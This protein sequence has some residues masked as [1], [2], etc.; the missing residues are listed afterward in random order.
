MGICWNSGC[1][2]LKQKQSETHYEINKQTNKQYLKIIYKYLLILTMR[3]DS[4]IMDKRGENK[5]RTKACKR[6]KKHM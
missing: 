4:R 5:T 1:D 2:D 3:K 6:L